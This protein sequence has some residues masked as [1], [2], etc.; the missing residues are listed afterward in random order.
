MVTGIGIG[1]GLG[2]L[3]GSYGGGGFGGQVD[4][5]ITNDLL[6]VITGQ[7]NAVG[8]SFNEVDAGYSETVIS[9]GVRRAAAFNYGTT[10]DEPVSGLTIIGA[11]TTHPDGDPVV[12]D[13]SNAIFNTVDDY[14]IAPELIRLIQAGIPGL[15]EVYVVH[16]GVN[17]TQ[18]GDHIADA[19]YGSSAGGVWINKGGI[20]N[21]INRFKEYAVDSYSPTPDE[22]Y[23]AF[24]YW[25]G[26]SDFVEMARGNISSA[27]LTTRINALFS[28]LDTEIAPNYD[29]VLVI[30]PVYWGAYV[31]FGTQGEWDSAYSQIKSEYSAACASRTKYGYVDISTVL[32]DSASY[33]LTTSSA[34]NQ[35]LHLN[36]SGY[37]EV[38][39]L[40]ATLIGL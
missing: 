26:E 20:I 33:K 8:S 25:Q 27:D 24:I 14:S 17:G 3:G 21:L 38:A 1:N 29:S 10:Y 4:N 12:A 23:S 31:D 15:D 18:I 28:Y 11:S 39:Q 22:G 35:A 16:G 36:P 9:S 34:F 2:L 5:S 30:Q 37:Y 7:S 40:I 13:S 6:V 32:A 19:T